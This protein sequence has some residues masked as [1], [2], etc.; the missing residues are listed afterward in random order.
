MATN[1][2][3]VMRAGVQFGARA[4]LIAGHRRDRSR[5]GWTDA[6]SSA[7]DACTDCA[8]GQIDWI[9][10]HLSGARLACGFWSIAQ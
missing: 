7:D 5:G 8:C 10:E 6:A 3:L 9:D 4:L 2:L 1:A